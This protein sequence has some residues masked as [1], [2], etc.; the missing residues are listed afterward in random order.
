MIYADNM[1]K[2]VESGSCLITYVWSAAT[3]TFWHMPFGIHSADMKHDKL[4]LGRNDSCGI[5]NR[6]RNNRSI[7]SSIIP[8]RFAEDAHL[9]GREHPR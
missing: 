4:V 5:E 7:T 1:V 3:A 2:D 8:R 6:T 9:V